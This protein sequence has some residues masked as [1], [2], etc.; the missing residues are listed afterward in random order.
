MFNP[1]STA[2]D[3]S[4]LL[5]LTSPLCSTMLRKCRRHFAR[6][7]DSIQVEL[8]GAYSVERMVSLQLYR[9]HTSF[10]RALACVILTPLPCLLAE[11][12]LEMIPL[13]SPEKGIKHSH[14]FWLRASIGAWM[15]TY[16]ILVQCHHFLVHLPMTNAQMI[17]VSLF[18]ALGSMA[19]AFGLACAIGFPVPFTIIA[20]APC[21]C[22]IMG[23]ALHV[24]WGKY[25]QATPAL[26]KELRFYGL[27]LAT[28]L[29][30]T[31]IYPAYTYGFNRLSGWPQTAFAVIL[32]G[33]KIA[34]KNWMSYLMREKED[35]KPEFVVFHV[36]V[37]HALF[38]ACCLQSSTSYLTLVLLMAIDFVVA[39][40]SLGDVSAILDA[41]HGT[42]ENVTQ[43][44]HGPPAAMTDGTRAKTRAK[45]SLTATT[46]AASWITTHYLEAAI[47][48]LECDQTLQQHSSICRHT[49]HKQLTRI[50]VLL[51]ATHF[52]QQP[53]PDSD[54]GIRR[55]N[56]V[57]TNKV[58][59]EE[60]ANGQGE[61]QMLPRTGK[62]QEHRPTHQTRQISPL[63]DRSSVQ[64][65]LTATLTADHKRILL[66]M[67]DSWRLEFV[68]QILHVLYLTEFL[69]LV[70]LIEVI[71]PIVYSKFTAAF[72]VRA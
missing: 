72:I 25:F 61:V 46:L 54:N 9:D 33:M 13:E 31:Y 40:V 17:L 11:V 16:A 29:G 56:P 7:W 64:N 35:F 23:V 5:P 26:K 39:C 2:H 14:L 22:V 30:F 67:S 60:R 37:F 1:E 24:V 62:V 8:H 49:T 45:A 10:A 63:H 43:S 70:E 55:S 68:Q 18:N 59:P 36:E 19:W 58:S 53:N 71:V 51:S 47:F 6:K 52:G 44:R 38:L 42:V 34:A 12:V 50:Q 21:V 28:Q 57:V 4:V 15:L 27:V 41:I 32:P 20:S 65:Q 3:G 48:L 66:S 69:L